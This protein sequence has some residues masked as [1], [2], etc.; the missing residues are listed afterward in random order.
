MET[1]QAEFI[2]MV[3]D[4]LHA[5]EQENAI[6]REQVQQHGKALWFDL[7]VGPDRYLHFSDGRSL[8]WCLG[9][10]PED[11]DEAHNAATMFMGAR[12]INLYEGSVRV[13]E[14]H[15]LT[16][17]ETFWKSVNNYFDKEKDNKYFRKWYCGL[18]KYW[19]RDDS[20]MNLVCSL[21]KPT[22]ATPCPF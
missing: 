5:L 2:A 10:P 6:L 3:M 12:T 19:N 1:P 18:Y 11:I 17:F 4:R 8:H 20:K 14:P 22:Q 13:G 9:D 7:H 15:K 21:V 16:T